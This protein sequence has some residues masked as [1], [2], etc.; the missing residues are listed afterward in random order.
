MQWRFFLNEIPLTLQSA[1]DRPLHSCKSVTGTH[2]QPLRSNRV[3]MSHSY[4][5]LG[6]NKEHQAS[7]SLP[8]VVGKPEVTF[9]AL[10]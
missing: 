3:H 10:H 4:L 5:I 6:G 8:C 2:R 1:V 7:A 9:K